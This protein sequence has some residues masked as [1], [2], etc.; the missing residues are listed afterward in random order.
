MELA[1]LIGRQVAF[2]GLLAGPIILVV[3]L[4]RRRGWNQT[5][6]FVIVLGWALLFLGL[7]AMMAGDA[8]A[9]ALSLMQ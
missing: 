4:G 7:N 1:M 3:L 2:V 9:D 8:S 6:V 5:Y